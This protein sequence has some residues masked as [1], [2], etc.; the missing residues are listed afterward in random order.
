MGA[1][2]AASAMFSALAFLFGSP[3]IAAVILIEAGGLGGSMLP[4]VL[5][6]GLLA[7][8]IGSLVWIGMG[9][10]TGLSTSDISISALQ[11]PAFARPDAADL[12][13][14]ILLAAAVAVGAVAIFRL[15]RETQRVAGSRP[16]LVLPAIGIA[17]LPTASRSA[18]SGAVRCSR[19]SSSAQPGA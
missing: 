2:I 15:G 17:G 12:G 5:V 18:A 3:I 10:W 11:L 8:G 14:T 16:F 1:V 6:P 4:L 19:P 13:W 9:S 7:S